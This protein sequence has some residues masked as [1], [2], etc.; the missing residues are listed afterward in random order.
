[1]SYMKAEDV[2]LLVAVL[3]HRAGKTRAR[4]SD[5][6]LRTISK[7]TVL[8]TAFR[9]QVVEWAEEFGVIMYPL[10]RGGYGLLAASSLEGAKPLRSGA[11]I[12]PELDHF[13]AYGAVDQDALY[14][15]LGLEVEE[16]ED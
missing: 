7:R 10:V 8:K 5:L 2:A 6:T 13:K 11:F 9:T 4:I 15:E 1:M 3:L 16:A 12:K 14:R